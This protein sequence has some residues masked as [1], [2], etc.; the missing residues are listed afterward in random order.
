VLTQFT[1]SKYERLRKRPEFIRLSEA[2]RSFHTAH[3][4]IVWCDVAT[5]HARI[6]ITVSRK[7]GK[8]VVRN[9]IKRLIREY[10][11]LSKNKFQKAEYNII[12]K[13]GAERLLF[14]DV[15]LELDKALTVIV[16]S[17]KC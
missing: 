8:A 16:S 10:F 14:Q 9:H 3:F 17:R 7:V 2:G 5:C 13:R 4:I 1:F 12:A 11:R 6:G 15:R